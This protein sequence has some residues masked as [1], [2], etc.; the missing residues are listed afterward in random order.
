MEQEIM[1]EVRHSRATFINYRKRLFN[2][3]IGGLE[4]ENVS[5]IESDDK[6]Q[7]VDAEIEQ[8]EME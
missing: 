3:I 4:E 2:E 6:E 7:E 5:E 8:Q 1:T